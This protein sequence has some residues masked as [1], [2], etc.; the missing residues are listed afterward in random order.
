MATSEIDTNNKTV[1]KKVN[2]ELLWLGLILLLAIIMR[3]LAV[4]SRDMIQMD[5]ASYVRMAENLLLGKAPMEIS[6]QSAT[7][8]S[9]LFPFVTAAIAVVVRNYVAAGYIV[10]ILFSSLLI[11][12]TYMLGRVMWSQKVGLAAVS[13]V[14]VLPVLVDY[15]SII[16]GQNMFA[17]WLLGGIFFGYRM[18]FTKRCMCGMLA[19]TCM[20]LAFLSSP[21]TL[22]YVIVLMGMLVIIGLRQEVAS[23]ANKA[24]AHF[25]LLFLLFAVPG[26]AYMTYENGSFTVSD[27]P[28]DEVYASVEQLPAGSLEREAEIMGLDSS[29][30]IRLVQ[31]E[32]G[33]G[34]FESLIDKPGATIEAA[35]RNAYHD[36][37][38]G[39]HSLVPVWLI[40]LLGLGMFRIA[41]TKR[42]ALKYGYFL[43]IILPMIVL[44]LMWSD[45]SYVLP[46]MGIFL[47][48]IAK[49]WVYLEEWG[50]G[51]IDE[52]AGWRELGEKQKTW[53]KVAVGSLVLAPLIAL[54][55]WNILRVDYDTE[56]KQAGEWLDGRGEEDIRVM[57]REAST[58]YYSGADL[59]PLPYAS[60]EEAIDYGQRNNV[61][62]LV[63]S[64][65]VVDQLRPQLEPLMDPENA[66]Q[67]LVEV[68]QSGAGTDSELIIY[69]L[70]S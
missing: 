70:E 24:A 2:S 61:D 37:F 22:Y 64:R 53:V 20:G 59:V 40:P 41:W 3:T 43:I 45:T 60:V 52:F 9:I 56:Y 10:S 62:Y 19:G 11:L 15:G 54:S 68:Y 32:D 65:P 31:I 36:Y 14:A 55:F 30:E 23:Y 4:L 1:G 25:I 33:D 58:A 48:F 67:G 21:T 16:D 57:S 50:I 34:F 12:P 69:K 51:T 44:P 26:V 66:P 42:E 47:L 27:R 38:R 49:G 46:F 6:G 28:V 17:F 5:E 7:Q 13:L 18:Q 39:A 8:F 63:L 35:A 29:G